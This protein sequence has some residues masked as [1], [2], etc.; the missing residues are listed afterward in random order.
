MWIRRVEED[1][2]SADLM[3][4]VLLHD[5]VLRARFDPEAM[6]TEDIYPKIWEGDDEFD[7]YLAPNFTELRRFYQSAA[8]NGQAALLAVT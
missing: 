3:R 5:A 8:A 2:S 1:F 6:A 4:C 7:N